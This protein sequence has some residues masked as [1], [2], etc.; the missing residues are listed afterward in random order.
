MMKWISLLIILSSTARAGLPPTTTQGPLD[1]S[2]VTTFNWSYTGTGVTV[3][4]SGV[5][6]TINI[7]GATAYTASDSIVLAGSNFTLVNDS[8]TPAASNYYGT[9]SGSVLGY[10]ALPAA[11]TPGGANTDVQFNN[12][13]AFGG[14]GNYT[15]DG[16][17]NTTQTGK[18]SSASANVSGLTASQP[19]VTDASDNLASGTVSSPLT[20]AAG[21]LGCQTASGSQAGCLDTTDWTAFNGKQAAL[22]FTAPL[23]DT[24][25]T[26]T[27]NVASGS[28]P[29]CLSSADWTTFNSKGSG[30]VTAVSVASANGFAG[31]SSGGATPALTISTTVNGIAKGNGTAFSAA[32]AGTDYSA[33]TSA[34]ATGILKSTTGTGALSI[35]AA[36]TDYQAPITLTTTGTS[37][38]ATFSGGTLNIPQ[39]A[40]TTYT[41][42]DSVSLT[43]SNFTLVNDSASG[44]SEYYGF[45]SGGA[46]GYHTL[47]SGGSPGGSNTDVQFNNS[48]AFGGN[49][50]YTTDGSGNTTQTGNMSANAAVSAYATTVTSGG[51]TTLTVSS[52]PIQYFT[53]TAAQ[54]IVLPVVSTLPQTGFTYS[55]TNYS[56][57]DFTVESSGANTIGTVSPGQTAFFTAILLTGTTAASWSKTGPNVQSASSYNVRL[58]SASFGGNSGGCAYLTGS[59]T[60]GGCVSSCTR[61]GVAGQYTIDFTSGCWSGSTNGNP[62]CTFTPGPN[63]NGNDFIQ[64]KNAITSASVSIQ[65]ESFNS[66]GT[67]LDD[68][69]SMVCVGT[70]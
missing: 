29:G 54:T 27:C 21:A 10:H 42:S 14:N 65:I 63:S 61:T 62:T 30:T 56:T 69:F 59:G 43:G 9:D 40:G 25:N 34:L 67:N 12:S 45:D 64:V 15:T 23:V 18:M 17:G 66:G 39:Y 47:P 46:L 51:T 8:A 1:A 58:E 24:T 41:A 26:V 28:Q 5:T 37:G 11:V 44:T 33:G 49:G 13:G 38:A 50:N 48:G 4:H 32:T 35:A 36:G 22:T 19:V 20:F 31:S 55:I 68:N 53:G 52:A 16:S 6:A 60:G 57:E 7:P 2:P 3:T 70:N